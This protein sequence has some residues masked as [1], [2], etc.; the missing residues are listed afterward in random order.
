MRVLPYFNNLQHVAGRDR[1]VKTPAE[2][3]RTSAGQDRPQ[4]VQRSIGGSA[5]GKDEFIPSSP[6][7]GVVLSYKTAPRREGEP[8]DPVI[9]SGSYSF[10][11]LNGS[12]RS[13]LPQSIGDRLDLKG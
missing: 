10:Y 7:S 1:Q 6:V 12:V 9:K 5:P 13:E 11:Q 4:Q 3:V 2:P 8:A